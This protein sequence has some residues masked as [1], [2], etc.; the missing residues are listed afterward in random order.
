MTK[1]GVT[2]DGKYYQAGFGLGI[3]N[4]GGTVQSQFL[5]TV[6]TFAVLASAAGGS[7]TYPFVIQ[8]GQTFI[9][10]ALIGTGWITNAM[11]GNVISSTDVGSSGLPIWE[12]NK[13]GSFIV[14]DSA[15]TVRVKMGRL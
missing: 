15:G 1:V 2:S 8:G 4:S 5:V 14:R 13:A 6:D 10:Q 9:A 3:D 12:L 7:A 11:I